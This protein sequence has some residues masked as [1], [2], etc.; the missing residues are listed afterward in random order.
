MIYDEMHK[1]QDSGDVVSDRNYISGQ[2]RLRGHRLSVARIVAE[3]EERGIEGFL[4]DFDIKDERQKVISVVNYC[5][6]EKCSGKVIRYCYECHKFNP[7]GEK[8]WI[9]AREFLEQMEV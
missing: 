1:P 4:E 5:A 9:T 7:N 8:L 6:G 2:P 3:I